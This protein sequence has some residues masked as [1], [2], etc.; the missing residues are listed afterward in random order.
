MY[1][2]ICSW[3][4]IC[5]CSCSCRC[6][7][8]VCAPFRT[9]NEM[10]DSLGSLLQW[11]SGTYFGVAVCTSSSCSRSSSLLLLL[12]LISLGFPSHMLLKCRATFSRKNAPQKAESCL[13]EINF[14]CAAIEN[15]MHHLSTGF[16]L[17]NLCKI[18]ELTDTA[19]RRRP[20]KGIHCPQ[21]ATFTG[22]ARPLSPF[23]NVFYCL[24]DCGS[25]C[26]LCTWFKRGLSSMYP[27][28]FLY[29]RSCQLLCIFTLC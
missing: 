22:F 20:Q 3:A 14:C 29:I 9:R 24:F 16:G 26:P 7:C 19:M 6:I 4:C 1:E 15:F 12:Q 21:L 23:S 25:H 28:S 13:I 5:I 27:D 17:W 10:R 8:D 11:M 2:C 18:S